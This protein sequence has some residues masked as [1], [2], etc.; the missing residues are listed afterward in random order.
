MHRLFGRPKP[1]AKKADE[2]PKP[3]MEE[4][5]SKLSSKVPELDEKIAQCDKELVRN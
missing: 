2:P 1:E 5:I 4:H 3:T